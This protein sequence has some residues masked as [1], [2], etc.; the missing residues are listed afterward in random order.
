MK[1][2]FYIF[3]FFTLYSCSNINFVYNEKENL[4][5]PLYQKT[6]VGISG[7]DLIFV[8]SYIPNFFGIN[9]DK[10]YDLLI[11]IKEEKRKG[12]VE[13]NQAI[14]TLRYE[15]KFL[16]TVKKSGKGCNVY[17]KEILSYFSIE[18]KSSGYNYGSDASLEKKYELAVVDNLNRFLSFLIDADLNN[19]S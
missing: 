16:Y 4:I 1:R 14:S 13:S 12:S 10:K 17:Q 2:I 7:L 3:I 6:D 8:K 18:P 9:K 5:N 19:C 15:L 11:N